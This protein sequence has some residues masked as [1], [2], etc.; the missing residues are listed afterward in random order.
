MRS[1][2]IS[3]EY[4]QEEYVVIEAR[5]VNK[6]CMYDA[7]LKITHSVEYVIILEKLDYERVVVSID[8][9]RLK[10]YSS[11]GIRFEDSYCKIEDLRLSCFVEGDCLKVR[12]YA[13]AISIKKET[14]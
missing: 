5:E 2:R 6:R 4:L 13:S 8:N 9:K 3:D 11:H 10:R 12:G 7:E 1:I 14:A